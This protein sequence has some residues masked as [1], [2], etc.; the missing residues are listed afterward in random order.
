MK[1]KL[2]SGGLIGVAL[3]VLLFSSF[4][5][6][7]SGYYDPIIEELSFSGEAFTAGNGTSFSV[8]AAGLGIEQTAYTTI[9]TSPVIEAPIPFNV[10]IP[11]W[12]AN[13][14]DGSSLD[15]MIR[16]KTA[17]GEWS[18]WEHAH[19]H[20][21]WTLDEEE[22]EIGELIAVPDGDG[23]HTHIQYS[24]SLSRYSSLTTPILQKFSLIF[25]DSTGGPTIEE[26]IAQQAAIDSAKG[27][28]ATDDAY[29]RPTVI[30]RDVW[31]VA[32]DCDYT[33][34]LVYSPATHM[35]VH[36][37]VSSNDPSDWAAIVRAIW[38]FHT[39]SREWGDIGYN[40]L[41]DQDGII[42]EGH[43]NEDYETLDVAGTHASGANTGS[44]GVALMGTFTEPSHG[45]PGIAPPDGMVDSLVELLS[46][47]ADQQQIDVYDASDALPDVDWGLTHIMG[48]RDVYGTTACPGDQAHTLI[49]TLIE[50]V[51]QNIGLTNEYIMIDERTAQV[52]LSTA[53]W[54]EGP[55]ECGTNT[56]SYYTLSTTDP[57]SS[58]HWGQWRPDI[59]A[60]GSYQIEVR[61]PY[62][63]T[64]RSETSGARYDIDHANGFDTVIV[65]QNSNLGLWIP[66]GTF[67]FFG[68]TE[69]TILLTDLTETDENLGLWLDEMRLLPMAPSL[70]VVTPANEGW[71]NNHDVTFEWTGTSAANTLTT[72]LQVSNSPTF[73]ETIISENWV[74]KPI[75]YT[76]LF[77]E[78]VAS[79]YWQV[80][81]VVS[82]TNQVLTSTV[83]F[84]GIDT[85]VPTSTLT[86]LYQFS[87]E[88]YML[89]WIGSDELSGIQGYDLS[90]RVISDTT[91]T[92]WLT[93]TI[94][95]A[96]FFTPPETD[97]EYEFRIQ[98][99]DNAE[100]RQPDSLDFPNTE[101]AI[102]LP[103]AIML[104]LVMRDG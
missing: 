28:R 25:I 26:M 80:T 8:S 19:T 64:G 2:L 53:T 61:V 54:N 9:Y 17:V 34:E 59:P 84:F 94:E 66:L 32:D 13:L 49:P 40:Y 50:R 97:Q 55:D 99:I 82:V 96:V 101:Q 60:A 11:Q 37:T 103:H 81:T 31:C 18:D 20:G 43:M 27:Q 91:W 10:V 44:M 48:H 95:T 46:W 73:S 36:H 6:P 30:S 88:S 62:C 47:K 85:A 102:D 65:D 72:T 58:N 93:G 69:N 51:A 4:I 22:L 86:H 12:I 41:I 24:I 63:N 3:I 74:T 29:P 14:P 33:E 56:H 92:P 76:H 83:W 16:T 39:Y 75:S 71:A 57:N 70:K 79:L 15:V 87:P 38:S 45:I 90:Y 21:D 78:D 35:V 98:A 77:T 5:T 100:N 67:E 52:T 68:G 1:F 23:R 42:Y 89:Q 104:P 7:A